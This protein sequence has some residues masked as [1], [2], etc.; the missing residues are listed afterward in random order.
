MA[1]AR[2]E[3]RF[4]RWRNHEA[5]RLPSRYMRA[6]EVRAMLGDADGW[7]PGAD[8][9]ASGGPRSRGARSVWEMPGRCECD[10]CAGGR[11]GCGWGRWW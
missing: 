3:R 5:R 8:R 2:R 11:R 7:T 9:E 4:R 10:D 1:T 6:S